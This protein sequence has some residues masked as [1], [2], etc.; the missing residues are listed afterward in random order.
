MICRVSAVDVKESHHLTL[1]MNPTF[2]TDRGLFYRFPIG[3][4]VVLACGRMVMLLGFPGRLA[5]SILS[6]WWARTTVGD[7]LVPG[8]A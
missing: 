4:C 3:Y 6:V 7:S 5:F 2:T 1:A 8:G